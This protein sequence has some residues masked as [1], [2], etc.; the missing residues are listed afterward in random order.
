VNRERGFCH[1]LLQMFEPI[2]AA[3]QFRA[4]KN[5]QHAFDST[6]VEKRRAGIRGES[7][8]Q[9][10]DACQFVLVLFQIGNV[11]RVLRS[12]DLAGEQIRPRLALFKHGGMKTAS[13]TKTQ[14]IRRRIVKQEI[15]RVRAEMRNDVPQ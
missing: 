3:R 10:F 1:G 9:E 15:R 2:R 13:K 14:N 5:F 11:D 12:H 7:F 4:R 8:P 6:A